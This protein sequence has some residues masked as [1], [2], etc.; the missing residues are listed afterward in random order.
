MYIRYTYLLAFAVLFALSEAFAKDVTSLRG[1]VRSERE[2]EPLQGATVDLPGLRKRSLVDSTGAFVFRGIPTGRHAIRVSIGGYET[3]TD[4]VEVIDS[5]SVDLRLRAKAKR[6]KDITVIGEADHGIGMSFMPAVQGTAIYEGKKN[7][8]I[9]VAQMDANRATNNP[10][11]LFSKVPGINVIENDGG[12][13]QMG[14]AVRGLNPNRIT[15]FNSRQNGYDISADA[16]GYPESYYTPPAEGVKRIEVVRGAASLQYGSQFGGLL[17][18]VMQEP[19]PGTPIEFHSVQ[20][21]G[22]YGLFNSYNSLGGT[23][24][25]L[26]YFGFYHHKQ[27]EG[28]R[29]NSAYSVNTGYMSSEYT[30]NDRLKVRFEL[31]L[32]RYD[33]QQPG[34]LTEEQF[35]VDPTQSNR[36]RNWFNADWNLPALSVDYSF[37]PLSRLN[38]RAFALIAERSAVGNLISPNQPDTKINRNLMV[39]DYFNLG[40][41]LRYIHSYALGEHLSTALVGAR[42]YSGNTHRRQGFGSEGKDANYTFL[43]PDGLEGSDYRFPS[44]NIALFAENIFALTSRLSITPGVRAELIRTVA[45]GYY[46]DNFQK[47]FEEKSSERMF[48][49]FGLGLSYRI[50]NHSD[51]YANASQA[52]SGVNFND[53]RVVNPSSR[54]D[55]NLKDVTGFNVDFGYRG[56][57]FEHVSFDVGGFYLQYNDRIGVINQADNNFNIYRY[58]TNVSDSRSLGLE[59]Y[60]EVGV[61][62][63]LDEEA[64]ANLSVFNSLAFVDAKYVNSA[65]KSVLG[66]RV[67]YAPEWII[68]SGLTYRDADLSATIQ[69]SFVSEQ[70]SDATNTR[71][72]ITAING[73]IPA[74]HVVDL[75]GS[76]KLGRYTISAGINNVLNASYY[77]RRADGY[78]GPGI[79]PADGRSFYLSAGLKI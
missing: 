41:E 54:V 38:A 11:Q 28:Y 57:V 31:T 39:D 52:Y 30:P 2:H 10:R 72:T 49:L 58:R 9:L 21:G 68:R 77:T 35:K 4:S 66:K 15:E 12:G 40:G 23:Y 24:G 75:S 19:A 5:T 62:H 1:T 67:E 46:R 60:I 32:M 16:L 63:W 50:N 17:N 18:F 29:K 79:L 51:L 34:G 53:I 55:S 25:A 43:H 33:M 71:Y 65:Y 13:V 69:H 48:P 22:S 70:F 26:N 8:V 14:I 47:R 27:G 3:L 7:E 56:R 59:S 42:Y 74:Y 61:L 44:T 37:S 20:T 64:D 76:Y 36:D 6:G 45:T 73:V 78:P